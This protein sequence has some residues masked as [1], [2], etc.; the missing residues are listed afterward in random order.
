VL[1]FAATRDVTKVER[2]ALPLVAPVTVARVRQLVLE[3]FPALIPWSKSVRIAV[4]GEYASEDSV[5]TPGSEVAMI[6]PVAG[7]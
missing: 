7:G 6:P 3:A 4:N 2:M 1:F 5:V